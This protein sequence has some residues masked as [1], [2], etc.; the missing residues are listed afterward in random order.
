MLILENDTFRKELK[1]FSQKISALDDK[2]K[3]IKMTTLLNNLISCVRSLD[4]YHQTLDLGKNNSDDLKSI[5]ENIKSIRKK[6]YLEL[7]I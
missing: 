4:G 6:L 5:R 3:E 2:E 7:G 1:E